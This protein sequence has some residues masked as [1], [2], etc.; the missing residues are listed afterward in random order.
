LKEENVI[1]AK[2][3]SGD[4]NSSDLFTKNL[5]GPLF[6]KHLT[7]YC[8]KD[9]VAKKIVDFVAQGDPQWEGV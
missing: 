3:I 4:N 8:G 1:I 6:E 7:M 5:G 9:V 2:W